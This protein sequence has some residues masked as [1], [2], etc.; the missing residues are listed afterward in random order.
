MEIYNFQ[1]LFFIITEI[2]YHM[3]SIDTVDNAERL[4]QYSAG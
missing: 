3:Q 2:R 4:T 1:S